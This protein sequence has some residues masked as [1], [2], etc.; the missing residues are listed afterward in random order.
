MQTERMNNQSKQAKEKKQRKKKLTKENNNNNNKS[1]NGWSK[2]KYTKG[3][4][5]SSNRHPKISL[6]PPFKN[7]GKIE[8]KW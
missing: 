8:S 4:F 7:G 3:I 5:I 2:N 1:G 6:K